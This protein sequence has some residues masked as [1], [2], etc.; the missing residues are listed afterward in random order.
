MSFK[1]PSLKENSLDKEKENEIFTRLDKIE[2]E[3]KSLK[4]KMSIDENKKNIIQQSSQ[5]QINNQKSVSNEPETLD[6]ELSTPS[7]SINESTMKEYSELNVSDF[8]G[9]I[10]ISDSPQRRGLISE[11]Q[12][13]NIL[14]NE[15][16][17]VNN[18]VIGIDSIIKNVA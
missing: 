14:N 4:T 12:F 17:N 5:D 13:N 9:K 7:S 11:N 1:N 16:N 2:N 15:N 3:I 18:D 8:S 10:Y 6:F